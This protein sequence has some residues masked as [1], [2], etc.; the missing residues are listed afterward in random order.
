V[1]KSAGTLR[2]YQQGKLVQQV[3]AAAPVVAYGRQ[4]LTVGRGGGASDD[5]MDGI[6]AS[7]M[8]WNVALSGTE[9]A[10]LNSLYKAKFGLLWC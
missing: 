9:V 1:T 10:A 8:L 3:A 7:A 4:Q 6:L 2:F 5:G